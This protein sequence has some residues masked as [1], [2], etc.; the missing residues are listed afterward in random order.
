MSKIHLFITLNF[1]IIIQKLLKTISDYN[2]VND[3]VCEEEEIVDVHD[4][5][6]V[7]S[8]LD[9]LAEFCVNHGKNSDQAAVVAPDGCL[10]VFSPCYLQNKWYTK[11]N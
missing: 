11:P 8:E 3:V 4:V 7:S 10:L 1:N 9:N 6:Y 5:S 2:V